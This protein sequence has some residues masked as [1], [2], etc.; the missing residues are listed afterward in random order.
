MRTAQFFAILLTALALVP[1][2]AHLFSL[3]NKLTMSQ[4]EYFTTQQAYNGWALLGTVLIGAL[5]ADL[6][7]ALV[8]RGQ[9][10]A[11]LLA[12]LGV[13]ALAA[14][15]ALF[16]AFTFPANEATSNWTIAPENWDI[17]RRQWEYS[18]A[19]NAL[20][21]FVGFCAIVLASVLARD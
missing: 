5:V 2:G 18:H 16:F 15:F 7:L 1:A 11:C 9:W 4:D 19:A 10:F 12:I 20:I 8:L 3:P 13:L 6:V 17:L 21:I 14:T